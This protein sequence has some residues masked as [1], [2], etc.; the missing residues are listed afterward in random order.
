MS[1]WMEILS[2]ST[3]QNGLLVC[4][5]SAETVQHFLIFK[6]FSLGRNLHRHMENMLTPFRWFNW[7]WI[8]GPSSWDN[9]AILL[10]YSPNYGGAVCLGR[11]VDWNVFCNLV[12]ISVFFLIELEASWADGG[13][14]WV[15][16]RWLSA[17]REFIIRYYLCP[18]HA[19]SVTFI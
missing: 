16:H 14:A 12:P 2:G 4:S 1:L 13:P 5:H 17:Q 3:E 19:H 8:Q 7:D 18:W 6:F 15:R 11:L 9:S 10:C